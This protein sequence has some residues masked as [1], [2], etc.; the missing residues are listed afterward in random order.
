MAVDN[1][2]QG[3]WGRPNRLRYRTEASYPYRDPGVKTEVPVGTQTHR[4]S[5]CRCTRLQPPYGGRRRG[6]RPQSVGITQ[7]Y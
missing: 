1:H 2:D 3:P 6:D 5:L 4:H 7:D